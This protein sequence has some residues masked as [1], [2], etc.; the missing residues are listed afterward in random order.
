MARRMWRS[1]GDGARLDSARC[2]GH[3]GAE[4]RRL[5]A[6]LAEHENPVRPDSGSVYR[7]GDWNVFLDRNEL[8]RDGE[9]IRIE[10][11]SMRLLVLLIENGARTTTREE[12]IARLWGGRIVS[13]DAITKQISKLRACLRD[14]PR[15]PKLIRTVPKV[16]VRLLREP[17][18]A[19]VNDAR[20][21]PG[22]R[23]TWLV[24]GLLVTLLALAGLAWRFWPR[25]SAPELRLTER[26]LTSA[27]GLEIEPAI[28]PDGRWFAYVGRAPSATDSALYVRAVDD[29]QARRLTP[30]GVNASTPAWSGD[31]RIAYV[32]QTGDSCAIMAGSPLG[33]ARTAAS[34]V[35]TLG[36]AWLGERRLVVAAQPRF[37][38]AFRLMAIDL[39][40]GG[41]NV[42]TAPPAGAV[43]DRL[44]AV[45]HDGK[46]VFFLRTDTV[47]IEHVLELDLATGRT[48]PITTESAHVIG[49]AVGAHDD[50]LITSD[51]GR[52]VLGLWA[53]HLPTRNWRQLLPHAS[54]APSLS[55]DGRRMVLSHAETRMTL[56]RQPLSGGAPEPVTETTLVDRLP[57]AANDGA[58]AFVSTRS[59][60]PEIWR[61]NRQD[62]APDQITAFNGRDVQDPSWSADGRSLAVT[63]AEH[64]NF[65]LYLVDARTGAARRLTATPENERHPS[66]S[67]DGRYLYFSR[68]RAASFDLMRL[69]LETRGETAVVENALRALPAPDGRSLYF[70][71]LLQPGLFRLSL[72]DGRVNQLTAWPDW[73]DMR[74]W[75]V[76]RGQI[77]GVAEL[78][79]RS[80]LMRL[81]PRDGS[82]RKTV[83]L[84]D[85]APGSGLAIRDSEAIYAR[86]A[87]AEAD[88]DLFELVAQK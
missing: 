85:M 67:P 76:A 63:V 60:R 44:P 27:P 5:R 56:W 57:V 73:S 54:G 25:P 12:I 1:E 11:M 75:T 46:R 49:L 7:V 52:G 87:E 3:N 6:D 83:E 77:W 45:S 2:E 35:A 41:E 47:G 21:A 38:A 81:D 80:V 4:R 51:R 20:A 18:L 62:G 64:N 24:A 82:I 78:A 23:R 43:G 34:C 36:L 29:G 32:A 55:A 15:D 42:L 31:G 61:L 22:R 69:D 79:G 72:S 19:S 37:G 33:G 74:N 70:S 16:G 53:L 10:P 39:A 59:G 40:T 65:D 71:R 84:K 88:V 13:D 14:D 8:E 58:L 9:V 48:Q 26:P 30:Q 68:S 17:Q 28:S 66:F 50:L 86:K